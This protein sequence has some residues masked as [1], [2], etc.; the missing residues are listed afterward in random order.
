MKAIRISGLNQKFKLKITSFSTKCKLVQRKKKTENLKSFHK[1]H[2][3]LQITQSKP[4]YLNSVSSIGL[5]SD[6]VQKQPN[7]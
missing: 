1:I 7:L 2:I 6:F 4:R 5:F 3:S